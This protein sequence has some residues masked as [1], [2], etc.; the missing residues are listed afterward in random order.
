MNDSTLASVATFGVYLAVMVA[1][2][3][4]VY[5]RTV[6]QSDFVLGGRQLNSW[7]AGLSANASDFSGW[8]LLGLPGAIY[9]SGL[10]EAWIAVGLAAGFAGSWI[11]I[12]PRLRVYTERVSDSRFGGE[13]DSLTLS[14]FLENR[15][16]DRSRALRAVSAVLIIVFY[17]FYVASGLVAMAALFDQVFGLSPA[18]AIVIGVS[19][20]VL[21]T[22]LGG[23]LAV[24]YTDV[25]QAV[26]MWAALL[27]VPVMALTAI[28]GFSG[29]ADGVAGRGDDLLSAVGG[30]ALDTDTGA[31]VSTETLGWVVIVS[32]LA[33]GFGYFGQ[34]HILARFMGIR[35]VRDIPKAGFVSV[36]WAVSAM[37]LA[38]VVGFIGIAY[39]DTPLDTPEQVF[40][41]LIEALTHPLV[42]GLLLAAILAAVMSTADSQLLVAASTLTEDGYKAFVNE[43]ASPRSLL[44]ISR[45]TV[46]AV[47][48]VAAG[49]ALWG[50]QSVMD[51]VG[52]AWAGFG[53]GFG[54]VLLLALFWKR[55]TWVGALAGMVVGGATAIIWDIVDGAYLETGL[56]AMVPAVIL[57]F[58]AIFALNGLGRVSAQ[59]EEDFD[60][61]VREIGEGRAPAAEPTA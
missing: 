2:G 51:L 57:S 9:V 41:R 36:A 19:I 33:W 29:L 27:V 32:G 26:M 16:N 35:S 52:Y 1:I 30:T 17:F 22:V 5:R 23:F 12:A 18:P 45:G 58:V 4:W 25:I 14:S 6:S 50:N 28:G 40:P 11:L 15:F 55:M 47:A 42:A 49:V 43:N 44:W 38:V 46:V 37:A 54:P 24:S 31:W 60:K 56:Y 39:F 48:A 61:V 7:V 3:L 8:L 21:Y 34:P 13:S 53:A 20:V 10:G 59:M